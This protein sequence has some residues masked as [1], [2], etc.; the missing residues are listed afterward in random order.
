MPSH[1]GLESAIGK[2][3][4]TLT[5]SLLAENSPYFESGV[6][7]SYT[8]NNNKLTVSALALNG[9]QRITRLEGNSLMSW[10]SQIFYKPTENLTLNYSTFIGAKQ[11][12]Q[13]KRC[14][15]IIITSTAS[16][17]QMINLV[18]QRDSI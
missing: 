14:G 9:W 5:R 15:V 2:D 1:I 13:C 18:L 11:T 10:G 4:W 12:R 8:T 3:N 7:L 6:K 16:G 17:S